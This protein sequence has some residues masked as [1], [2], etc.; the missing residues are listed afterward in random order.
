MII[1][2]GLMYHTQIIDYLGIPF[3]CVM[4][5]G[6]GHMVVDCALRLNKKEWVKKRQSSSIKGDSNEKVVTLSQDSTEEGLSKKD[7]F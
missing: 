7:G 5:H 6:Y 3:I 4:C 1:Q 2:K